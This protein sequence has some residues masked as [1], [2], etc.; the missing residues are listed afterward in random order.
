MLTTLAAQN[1]GMTSPVVFVSVAL[2]DSIRPAFMRLISDL[3]RDRRISVWESSEQL[4]VG[5]PII[6]TLE[7][8][9]TTSSSALFL[10]PTSK[11]PM[12]SSLATEIRLIEANQAVVQRAKLIPIL[13]EPA[14]I[15]SFFRPSSVVDL[16]TDYERRLDELV[17]MVVAGAQFPLAEFDLDKKVEHAPILQVASAITLDL[18][19][20]TAT[21][22]E[23]L[24]RMPSRVFEELI[25]MLFKR[26]GYEVELTKRTRDGGRD[27]I[28]VRHAE[29]KV[30]YL[31][32]CKRWSP[33]RAVGVEPVRALF[34][35]KTLERATKAILATTARFSRDA[36]LIFESARWELE[37][38]DYDGV[39][40]WLRPFRPRQKE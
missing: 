16:T 24:H 12:S 19:E 18:L 33:D 15:P 13:V 17:E 6:R 35:V 32:E 40:E 8:A 5:D 27:V 22:P 10:I 14:L 4:R 23:E 37:P 28:A 39:V 1:L 30:K 20:R 21:S 31:I 29:V 2:K 7:L 36:M 34:G 26:F 11:S 3:K 25:A 38:R 9:I